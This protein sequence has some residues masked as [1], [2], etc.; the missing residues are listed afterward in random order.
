M[1]Q[2]QRVQG[3]AN[4]QM[5]P[6]SSALILSR[7]EALRE[8]SMTPKIVKSGRLGGLFSEDANSTLS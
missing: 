4:N 1:I 5:R 2:A 8:L 3:M 7:R 6:S